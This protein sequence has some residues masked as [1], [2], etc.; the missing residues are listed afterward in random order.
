MPC[1]AIRPRLA[2][3]VAN[4]ALVEARR[5]SLYRAMTRPRPA[6]APLIVQ[7]IGFGAAQVLRG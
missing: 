4:A 7:M 3:A 5:K 2:K 1:S 6:A